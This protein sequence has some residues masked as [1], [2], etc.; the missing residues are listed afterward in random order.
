MSLFCSSQPYDP[1]TAG[2]G[3]LLASG[4]VPYVDSSGI[5]RFASLDDG[6]ASNSVGLSASG[7]YD[8]A[9]IVQANSVVYSQSPTST[10]ANTLVIG[11]ISYNSSNVYSAF[12]G[13]YYNS[14]SSITIPTMSEL[15]VGNEGGGFNWFL[16]G[17][18]TRATYF[19]TQEPNAALVLYTN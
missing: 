16:D 7:G 4:I 5:H 13:T 9:Y 18:L 3:T 1:Y 12:N 17:W 19:P 10:V 2:V 15:A 11:G 6:S 14:G 8:K